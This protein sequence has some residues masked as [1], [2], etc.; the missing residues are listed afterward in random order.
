LRDSNN[1]LEYLF[2]GNPIGYFWC[3]LS[4]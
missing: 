4:V 3:L 2:D 1:N